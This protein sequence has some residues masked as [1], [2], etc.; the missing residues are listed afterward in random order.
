MMVM[1]AI[2]R[3]KDVQ[4]KDNGTNLFLFNLALSDVM[5]AICVAPVSLYTLI[6]EGW[7]FGTLFCNLNLILNVIF[8]F[9]SIHS[10][11]YM[12]IHKY[13]SVKRLSECDKRPVNRRVCYGMIAG[14]WI[15]GVF[16]ALLTTFVLTEAEYKVKTTQCG[17]KY[18]I[19][20]TK[21]VVLSL[22]NLL[23]NI[24]LPFIVM[25][26]MYLNIFYIIRGT[27][28]FRRQSSRRDSSLK[29][30][31]GE[32]AAINT[33]IIVLAC[34]IIC[35]LP[36]LFYTNYVFFTPDR[37]SI[38]AFLNPMAYYF[39]FTNSACNPVIY[40]FRFPDFK[41]GYLE[42]LQKFS[43][44]SRSRAFECVQK[45]DANL[46]ER[47]DLIENNADKTNISKDNIQ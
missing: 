47:I 46:K 13:L 45:T 7:H 3:D 19:F 21:S 29:R 44:S 9:T 33:L 11:M 16:F 27:A 10:L 28:D 15:W 42:I 6:H 23:L 32:K 24:V 1:I 18:P 37:D 36:Y 4:R 35:W 17:P 43:C 12:S 22:G 31:D 14:S 2:I 38:P 34:F 20:E 30:T 5:T 40:A 41:R 25:L 39:G 26:V 8:L